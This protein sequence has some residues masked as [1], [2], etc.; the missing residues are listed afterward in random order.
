[1]VPGNLLRI[2]NLK[3]ARLERLINGTTKPFLKPSAIPDAEVPIFIDFLRGMLETE[4]RDSKVGVR[5]A[6]TCV[7]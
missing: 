3:P 1:L 5:T 2:P 6:A 4:P 7:A